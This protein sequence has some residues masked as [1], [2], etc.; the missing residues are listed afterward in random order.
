MVDFTGQAAVVTGAGR[1]L[2]R[3]YALE[4]ARRGAAVVV[5]DLGGSM[6]GQGSDT[7]V[8]DQVVA[9]ITA[10][11]GTAVASYDSVDNPE[12][13]EAIV[14]AAVDR[15]GR[16]DAVIS[17]AGIFNSIPFD[18]LSAEDWRR[19]LG[20]HLDG[21]FYLA[22]PAYRVMRS[23]GYGR[24]VFIASSAGMFGQHLEAHYAAAKAGLVGLSNV[25]ALEGAPHG[26]LANTVLPFGISRMVTETLGD[27]K[28]L[29]ENGFFKAIRPELVAPLV[30][31]LASRGCEFSHQNFSACAG[32]FAR[33]FVG[34]GE[35]WLA[36][37][38]SN[39]TAEDI[40]AH[41]AEVAATESFT[42]PGSIYDEVFGVTERLGAFGS[43]RS[44]AHRRRSGS[45]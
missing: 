7:T 12:G 16:L 35:G 4:L 21:G 18:E 5:N 37:P 13:G 36:P 33:V 42:I 30:V 45:L 2:G 34:L 41:L 39:P 11:G 31:Y 19:M 25:I 6:A 8:A 38:D 23:Q 1:G 22:Q 9:E 24:F 44:P 10:A 15:F 20:V 29:E 32:R 40:A 3:V 14:R 17:N 27:P 43:A 26:I 28:V